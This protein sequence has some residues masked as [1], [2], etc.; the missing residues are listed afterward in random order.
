[1]QGSRASATQFLARAGRGA[2]VLPWAPNGEGDEIKRERAI[3]RTDD[4]CLIFKWQS[5]QSYSTQLANFRK[6]S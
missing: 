4:S 1:M 5:S 6:Q 3:R 2:G